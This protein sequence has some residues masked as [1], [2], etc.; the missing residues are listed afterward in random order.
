MAAVL[1]EADAVG[2]AL[3]GPASDGMAGTK[4]LVF[5]LVSYVASHTS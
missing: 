3:V 1:T 4:A 2:R 5:S